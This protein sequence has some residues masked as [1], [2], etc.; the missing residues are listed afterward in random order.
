MI[1]EEISRIVRD[2]QRTADEILRKDIEILHR[3][4]QEL[5]KYETLDVD[6]LV[7]I[8]KGEKLTRP[9]NGQDKKKKPRRRR[10][11]SPANGQSNNQQHHQRKAERKKPTSQRKSHQQNPEVKS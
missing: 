4:A 3:L 10:R 2:S 6:D 1:D 9:L 11:R 8:M 7:K 5:L